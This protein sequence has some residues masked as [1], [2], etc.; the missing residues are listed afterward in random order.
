MKGRR[1]VALLMSTLLVGTLLGGCQKDEGTVEEKPTQ[2]T[3]GE[4]NAQPEPAPEGDKPYEGQTLQLAHNFLDSTMDGFQAQ[5]T[6]FEEKYGCKVEVELLAE[7]ADEAESVLLTRAA[8]GNLPDI[9]CASSGAK[10]QEFAPADNIYDISGEAFVD[11]LT[12]EFIDIVDGD[13]GEVYG[14]PLRPSNVAGV[15]Y[16][17][18]VYEEL[19]LEIPTTWE[20][21]LN[22]CQV[23]KDSTDKAPVVG[24]Y[25]GAAGRQIL[26]LS[27]YY[28]VVQENPDF[29]EQY[30]NKEIT[31]SES[32]AYM[33]GLQKL[34]DLN[35][36]GYL[37]SDPLST[38]FDD[39]AIMLTEG[40]AVHT[41]SRTNIVGTI[42]NVAPDKVEDIGFFPLPDESSDVQGVAIW[43]PQCWCISQSS[44]NKELALLLFDFLV[45]DEGIAAYCEGTNPTGAFAV[46]GSQLPE[47]VSTVVKDAQE[48]ANQASTPVME[49]SCDI[50]GSN[51]ST[52]LSMVGTGELT[53]EKGVEEIEAD[54]AIDAQQKGIAGW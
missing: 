21:F 27:Q 16:N 1:V 7:N 31:L 11:R 26:F 39:S 45:S 6:A 47:D 18:K 43:L 30:T 15:F 34:Y 17:K 42:E 13:N 38:S 54:N 49:Y 19:K 5:F 14:V 24:A 53:P 40:T 3:E 9:F 37:N 48:W 44:E 51:L 4:G 32:P 29:A 8:T 28:Y 20:E 35:E 46:K 36:K 25:D 41:F 10:L 50:K 12:D 33:R 22:N 2:T 52:I 23:I